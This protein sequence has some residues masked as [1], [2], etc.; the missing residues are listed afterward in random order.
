MVKLPPTS[1]YQ[2]C[3]ALLGNLAKSATT[4]S[5]TGHVQCY[6]TY[7]T[8]RSNV[9][10]WLFH[11][12]NNNKIL[13]RTLNLKL[14]SRFKTAHRIYHES[15]FFSYYNKMATLSF[16][17]KQIVRIQPIYSYINPPYI[18]IQCTF[19][20]QTCIH[21]YLFITILLLWLKACKR[22]ITDTTFG[23]IQ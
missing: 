14:H 22:F 4:L 16:P 12:C 17:P 2:T 13:N 23:L 11:C 19:Y 15:S 8:Y 3:L 1:Q 20:L 7:L 10:H 21:I 5:R 18:I 9:L 6:K